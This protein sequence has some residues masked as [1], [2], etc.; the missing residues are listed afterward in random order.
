MAADAL[1]DGPEPLAGLSADRSRTVRQRVALTHGQHPLSVTLGPLALHADAA[2]ADD[3]R[4]DGRRCGNCRF[5][6]Q[7]GPHSYPKCGFAEPARISRG[8]GTDCRAWWPACTD[9]EPEVADGR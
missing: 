3:K 9:H 8:A 1:F 4:A 6:Q 5:R 2:P 7:T